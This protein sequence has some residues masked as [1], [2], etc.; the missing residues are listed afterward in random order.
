[1][2]GVLVNIQTGI[3]ENIIMVNSLEDPV[4]ENYKLFEMPM[5][6]MYTSEEERQLYEIIKEIDPDF[7]GVPKG[8]RFIDIG[9][10]KWSTEKG[11]YEE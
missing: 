5:V 3:V 8:E 1:M 4:L 11:F 2:K 9:V 7:I 10:T 6:E